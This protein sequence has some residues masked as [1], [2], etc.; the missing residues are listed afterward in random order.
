MIVRSRYEEEAVEEVA[1]H[2]D[3]DTV[4]QEKDRTVYKMEEH[5]VPPDGLH[6]LEVEVPAVRR[7]DEEGAEAV[8]SSRRP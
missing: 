1:D 7:S 3:I 4:D 2:K 6:I 5:Q 8:T